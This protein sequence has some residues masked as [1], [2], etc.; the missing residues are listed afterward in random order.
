MSSSQSSDTSQHEDAL[1]HFTIQEKIN[2]ENSAGK[3]IGIKKTQTT[4]Q[5]DTCDVL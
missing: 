5:G 3:S 2:T 1:S 4:D